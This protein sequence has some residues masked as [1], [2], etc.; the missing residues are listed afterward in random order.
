MSSN[1]NCGFSDLF[2]RKSGKHAFRGEVILWQISLRIFLEPS[3]NQNLFNC[4]FLLIRTPKN[5]CQWRNQQ[6]LHESG[7][8]HCH[9]V[10]EFEN[11]WFS[12]SRSERV[13]S[14]NFFRNRQ[15]SSET[16]ETSSTCFWD[17]NAPLGSKK[18]KKP[19]KEPPQKWF[20]FIKCDEGGWKSTLLTFSLKEIS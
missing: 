4:L 20:S 16:P 17:P 5:C 11:I 14:Q 13:G 12:E 8:E 9:L 18:P 1:Q 7:V 15:I 6:L 2:V 19:T 3:T 10:A